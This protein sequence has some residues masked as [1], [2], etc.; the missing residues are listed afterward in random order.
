MNRDEK[1]AFLKEIKEGKSTIECLLPTRVRAWKQQLDNPD[2][3]Y[4]KEDDLYRT[5]DTYPVPDK[6]GNM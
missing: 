2:V 6:K 1:I 4:C 5:K 3:F